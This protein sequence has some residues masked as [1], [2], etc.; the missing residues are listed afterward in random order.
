MDW[1]AYIIKHQKEARIAVGFE[2]K[3]GL[4]ARFKKLEGAKWSQSLK[5]WHLLDTPDYRKHFG[6]PPAPV[7]AE[8]HQER[9]QA[10]SQWLRSKR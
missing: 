6:L 3:P 2:K 9:I 5:V 8:A 1:K 4:I 7:L 10:F